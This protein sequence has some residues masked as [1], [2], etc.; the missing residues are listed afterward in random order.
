MYPYIALVLGALIANGLHD[1]GG[2]DFIPIVLALCASGP[3]VAWLAVRFLHPETRLIAL[4][5]GFQRIFFIAASAIA[6]LLFL[7]A[8]ETQAG[9]ELQYFALIWWIIFPIICF[10]LLLF[11]RVTDLFRPNGRART[12]W[13]EWARQHRW[14]YSQTEDSNVIDVEFRVVEDT[15]SDFDP[16]RFKG[17]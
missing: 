6:F 14:E 3:L 10:N 4:G 16:D 15:R 8:P 17:R 12:W 13:R 7:D 9:Y 5:H 11:D 2:L 1:L